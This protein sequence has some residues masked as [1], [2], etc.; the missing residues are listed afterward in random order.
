M[1]AFAMT[2]HKA[3]GQ[4]LEKVVV[5]LECCRGTESPYVMISRVTSLNGLL[6]LQHHMV[7]TLSTRLTLVEE[8]TPTW[9]PMTT[10]NIL[11]LLSK[12]SVILQLV[13][14]YLLEEIIFPSANAQVN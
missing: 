11:H 6:L 10:L 5:D 9:M 1:P 3:Q 14:Y 8:T 4:T 2:A 13:L 7:L 12:K